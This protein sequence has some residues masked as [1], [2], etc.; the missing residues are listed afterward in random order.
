VAPREKFRVIPIGLDLARFTTP[1]EGARAEFRRQAG[2]GNGDVL[3]TFV[4]RLVPI[5][6]V[7]LA[8]EAFAQARASGAPLRLAIVGDGEERA[9]LEQLARELGV[10]DRVKFVGYS[11][12]MVKVT[13]GSDIALLTSANEGTPVSLIEAAAAGKP[14]VATGVG[15]VADVVTAETGRVVPAGDAGALAAAITELAAD[16]AQRAAMGAEAQRHVLG[17][18]SVERLLT[19]IDQLYRELRSAPDR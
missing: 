3:L 8:L 9:G 14:A 17:R 1:P 18:F 5:K 2:A 10:A 7:D 13:A 11:D 15:G 16:P 6:R 4:G 19:D 12:D